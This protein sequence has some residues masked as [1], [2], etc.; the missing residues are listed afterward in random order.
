MDF[1]LVTHHSISVTHH[2]S[3]KIPHL[4]WH[5]HSLL[6]TQ[7]FS[8]VCEPHTC[9]LV[10]VKRFCG[11]HHFLFSHFPSF[12]P[13]TLPKH[14]LEPIFN[15]NNKNSNNNN[16]KMPIKRLIPPPPQPVMTNQYCD[17]E[18]ISIVMWRIRSERWWM[19]TRP[20]ARSLSTVWTKIPCR[21]PNRYVQGMG[22][23]K[24]QIQIQTHPYLVMEC[25]F[26]PKNSMM[27]KKKKAY[28]EEKKNF[29][30][31]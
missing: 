20:T 29:M 31:R 21:N 4:V 8:T 26:R 23:L 22:I 12:T 17:D 7:Y 3:L 1:F 30:M 18:R 11:T 6:I 25:S 24:P 15:H 14:K 9:H 10:R 16:N 19:R 27:K 13:V 2:L 28:N 5:H